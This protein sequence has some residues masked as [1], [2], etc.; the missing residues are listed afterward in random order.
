[1]SSHLFLSL[2]LPS[3]SCPFFVYLPFLIFLFFLPSCLS[4]HRLVVPLFLALPCL[5]SH[6]ST[7]PR[8]YNQLPCPSHPF[9]SLPF[10][11]LSL[12][13]VYLTFLC[14]FV[15]PFIPD[16]L[17]AFPLL[18]LLR[19]PS[20]PYLP[21]SY[22]Y[23]LSPHRLVVPLF[24]SLPCLLSPFP[25]FSRLRSQLPRLTLPPSFLTFA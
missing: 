17:L 25:S 18:S 2:S 8:L 7:F 6:F 1:M 4:S 19:L 11:F 12:L 21:F 23:C 3:L 20:L 10:P 16:P 13:S 5:T 9:P 24:L 15:L 14:P 22:L